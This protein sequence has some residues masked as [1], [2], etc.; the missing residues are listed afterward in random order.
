[1]NIREKGCPSCGQPFCIRDTFTDPLLLSCCCIPSSCIHP[2]FILHR[3]CPRDGCRASRRVAIA[4]GLSQSQPYCAV[5]K[6]IGHEF[7][8]R[9]R[10]HELTRRIREIREIRV[11]GFGSPR[12]CKSPARMGGSQQWRRV[13][14][15]SHG[16]RRENQKRASR[17][18]L[19]LCGESLRFLR[20]T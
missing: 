19:W 1:M 3:K 9:A 17:R 18:S 2:A 20:Q 4:A 7:T 15:Q 13:L 10:C 12:L 11:L 8:L 14:P 5:F 6:R 16:V